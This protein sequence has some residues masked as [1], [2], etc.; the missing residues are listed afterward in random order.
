MMYKKT[1]STIYRW[2]KINGEEVRELF[3]IAVRDGKIPDYHKTTHY[4]ISINAIFVDPD[5]KLVAHVC[6]SGR[7]WWNWTVRFEDELAAIEAYSEPGGVFWIRLCERKTSHEMDDEC[8]LI[9][10]YYRDMVVNRVSHDR[11]L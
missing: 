7:R 9:N 8:R 11:S 1:D 6:H 10:Q 2:V 3:Y 5:T 4:S